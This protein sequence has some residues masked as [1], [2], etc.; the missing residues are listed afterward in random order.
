MKWA[1]MVVY[2]TLLLATKAVLGQV[3]YEGCVDF[4][5]QPVASVLDNSINDVAIASI[6]SGQAIIQYNTRVLANLSP[7]TR[8]FFYAHECAHHA[9]AHTINAPS[10]AN[11][12][13]ADCWAAKTMRTK[14]GLSIL[15]L[16]AIQADISRVG[17]GD[18]THLPGPMRSI[19]IEK[20]IGLD[21]STQ[22]PLPP[23]GLPSGQ[24]MQ[25]CGCWGPNP[26][27]VAAEP[28]CASQA[29]RLN[30]CPAMCA[31]GHPAYGYVCQ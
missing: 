11:E 6:R 22:P 3:T 19:D 17:N 7:P 20:C 1:R 27:P 21:D 26:V 28:R 18:W 30:V 9:L 13:A 8:R 16:R 25:A 5:G 2:A 4:R 14:M 15:E 23:P 12:R 31:P 29:V 10:L 24:V